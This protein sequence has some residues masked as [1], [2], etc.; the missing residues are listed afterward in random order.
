MTDLYHI[1]DACVYTQHEYIEDA[2]A[3]FR[4]EATWIAAD[5]SVGIPVAYWSVEA[6]LVAFHFGNFTFSREMLA[7][8]AGNAE[9]LRLEAGISERLTEARN[10]EYTERN[11]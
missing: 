11:A 9:V 7:Q 5:P 6:T 2:R 10:L 3:A 4:P 8:A 1:T